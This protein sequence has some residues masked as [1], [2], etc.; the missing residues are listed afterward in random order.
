MCEAKPRTF[1]RRD[2]M[3]Q[4]PSVWA[5]VVAQVVELLLLTP[6]IR[7]SNP[8]IGKFYKGLIYCR[9]YRKE[10]NKEKEA[11]NGPFKKTIT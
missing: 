7:G 8:V 10:K 6:V 1:C 5:V 3:E 4:S 2:L 9:L 11:G